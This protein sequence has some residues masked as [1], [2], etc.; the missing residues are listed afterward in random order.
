MTNPKYHVC[1]LNVLQCTSNDRKVVHLNIFQQDVVQRKEHIVSQFTV[2]CLSVFQSDTPDFSMLVLS[3]THLSWSTNKWQL[4]L[5][6]PTLQT[7]ATTIVVCG[8][9][10]L[11]SLLLRNSI[12]AC[13]N[14]GI[15]ALT[16][17]LILTLVSLYVFTPQSEALLSSSPSLW[18]DCRQSFC[19]DP[20][21]HLQSR[22]HAPVI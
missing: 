13:Q 12:C 9:C 11:C 4:S 15:K 8:K 5:S 16:S 20:K 1:F 22:N 3:Y 21:P 17:K 2:T 18:P 7:K 10:E 19:L 14:E 6:L